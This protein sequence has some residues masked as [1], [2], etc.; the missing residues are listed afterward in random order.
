MGRD[1][2]LQE[3]FTSLLIYL[4]NISFGV[5]S[6]K[7]PRCSPPHGV[8]SETEALLLEPSFILHSKSPVYEPF[9]PPD[10]RF[11]SD[12]KGPYERDAHKVIPRL[13]KIIRSVIA[14][15]SRNTHTDG[16]YKLLEWPDRSCL[17]LY[18][19]ARIH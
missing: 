13:T 4:F 17:L 6:K 9:P 10:S 12:I 3:N 15:I 16:K 5:P 7:S 14:F 18:V 8:P 2:R 11:P 19:S 1:T